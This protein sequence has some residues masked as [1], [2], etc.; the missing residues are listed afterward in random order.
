MTNKK[1]RTRQ[2]PGLKI[3]K[4]TLRETIHRQRK[5]NQHNAERARSKNHPSQLTKKA[6]DAITKNKICKILVQPP[7]ALPLKIFYALMPLPNLS[8]LL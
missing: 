3:T 8:T 4:S 1:E 5:T 7:A 6:S 2:Q